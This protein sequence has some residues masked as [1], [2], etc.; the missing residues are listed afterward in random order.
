MKTLIYLWMLATVLGGEVSAQSPREDSPENLQRYVPVLPSVK[1]SFWQIDPKLGYAVKSVGGGVYVISD[2]GWQSAFLVTEEGVIVFDAPASFGKSIPS[3][4]SKVTDQPIKVLVYSHVHKDHIG[5]SA[6]F[7]S[8]K[9][10]KI[11]ALDTVSDFLRETNDLD[12]L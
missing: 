12:R 1:A 6:A 5:G 8:V 3:A 4:I 9:D 2:N 11:V 10:L 7:K